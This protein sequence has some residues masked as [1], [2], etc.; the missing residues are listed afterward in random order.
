[1]SSPKTILVPTDFSETAHAALAYAKMLAD[2]FGSTLHVV[3]VAQDPLTSAPLMEPS[4]AAAELLSQVRDEIERDAKRR[5]NS[6]L[7]E[8]E[9]KK[10]R[11][12]TDL[13]WGAA[14][15]EIEDY[16]RRHEI[17]L[18]VMGTHGRG[19]V[20]GV[21]LG[22][23]ADKLLRRAPCP[24]LVVRPPASAAHAGARRG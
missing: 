13:R 14:A 3:H 12:R 20:A 10:F 17:D 11:A 21:L 19:M 6:Q 9:Q 23:V 2:V 1:M 8:P 15:V 7:T 5:L 4:P 22:S 18:I 24:V 16:A